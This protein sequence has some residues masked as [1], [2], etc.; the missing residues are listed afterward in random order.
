VTPA[1]YV[2]KYVVYT[3]TVFVSYFEYVKLALSWFKPACIEVNL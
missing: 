3:C 1:Q 2:E